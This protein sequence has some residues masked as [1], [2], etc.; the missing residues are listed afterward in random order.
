[1]DL[2]ADLDFREAIENIAETY[3]KDHRFADLHADL[4][5]VG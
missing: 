5:F 4:Q 1:M 2:S 3:I